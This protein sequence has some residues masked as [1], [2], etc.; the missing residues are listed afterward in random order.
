MSSVSFP[1]QESFYRFSKLKLAL[2]P[3][4]V[5]VLAAGASALGPLVGGEQ[6]AGHHVAEGPAGTGR[7]PG[8]TPETHAGG[9]VGASPRDLAGRARGTSSCRHH[10]APR[11]SPRSS[12]PGRRRPQSAG[13]ELGA[14]FGPRPGTRRSPGSG[15]TALVSAGSRQPSPGRHFCPEKGGRLGRSVWRCRRAP[16]DPPRP[17]PGTGASLQQGIAPHGGPGARTLGGAGSEL[18]H[19]VLT[20]G[21]CRV[22]PGMVPGKG[23][24]LGAVRWEP[25]AGGPWARGSVPWGCRLT[26]RPGFLALTLG[27]ELPQPQGGAPCAH[28]P[29]HTRACPGAVTAGR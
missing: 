6:W 1:H 24:P 13:S 12:S 27:E 16:S 3:P 8:S 14:L 22:S 29:P 2:C 17:P 7:L 9:A 26:P 21:R 10:G 15:L 19:A 18:P 28:P 23:D 4:E 25:R 5:A 20:R 11:G